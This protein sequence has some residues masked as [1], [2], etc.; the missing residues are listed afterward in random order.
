MTRIVQAASALEISAVRDLFEEYAAWLGIDL[1]FQ[2]FEAELAALPGQYSPPAGV[3]LL[4]VAGGAYVGCVGL[5]P[6]DPPPVAE[7]KRLWVRPEARGDR[8]GESLVRR[9]LSFASDAGYQRVRLDTLAS[10]GSARHLYESLGFR[11][12]EAYRF[13]PVQGARYMELDLRRWEA[14][15]R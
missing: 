1:G 7:L 4:A 14:D 11:E 9:A 6:L 8:L 2:E 13:N 10:M 12:I 3:L 15:A 5:R